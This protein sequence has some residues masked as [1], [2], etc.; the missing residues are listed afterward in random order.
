MVALRVHRSERGVSLME[1]L[2]ALAIM[3][4]I[5]VAIISGIS[6]SVKS[7]E[8]ARKIISAESL[9]RAELDYIKSIKSTDARYNGTWVP[10]SWEYTVAKSPLPN[11]PPTWDSVHTGLPDG[12]DGYS[13][14][15]SAI[16]LPATTQTTYDTDVQKITVT[17]YLNDVP[18]FQIGTNRTK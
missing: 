3:S 7:N 12:Y 4:F 18:A 1:T 15:C 5:A 10:S 8:V 13:V 6:M 17:V 16:P 14:T 2:V 9:A 11:T